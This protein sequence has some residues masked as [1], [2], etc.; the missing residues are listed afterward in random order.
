V[1]VDSRADPDLGLLT[2]DEGLE[3]WEGSILLSSVAPYRLYVF[4]RA[5]HVPA[6]NITEAARLSIARLRDLEPACR[7]YATGQLLGVRN[8]EWAT[9]DPL[10]PDDFARRFTPAGIEVHET[11]YA[12]VH[13]GDGGLFSGHGI[14]VRIRPDGTFQEAVVE[15]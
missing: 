11:G 14:G 13:F 4:A 2:W 6:R 7:R 10:S 8:S 9:G 15:G 3:W 5:S 1:S 12:E